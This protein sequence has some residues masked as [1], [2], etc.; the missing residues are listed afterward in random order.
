MV[1]SSTEILC[2]TL[3][4]L[5]DIRVKLI[6]SN[7]SENEINMLLNLNY[8]KKKWLEYSKKKCCIE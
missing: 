7:V 5:A 2:I 4:I 8:A 1:V 6:Y 3:N